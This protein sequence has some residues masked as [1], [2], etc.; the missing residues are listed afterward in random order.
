MI[1]RATAAFWACFAR[2]PQR[3]QSARALIEAVDALLTGR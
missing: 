3:V 1:S 2:L